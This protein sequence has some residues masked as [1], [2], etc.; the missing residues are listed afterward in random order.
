MFV[1][2]N[3]SICLSYE[4][5]NGYGYDYGWGYGWPFVAT[6]VAATTAA[7]L[8]VHLPAWYFNYLFCLLLV[9]IFF[10]SSLH[11]PSHSLFCSLIST[12]S[13][14][15]SSKLQ[16]EKLSRRTLGHMCAYRILAVISG[17]RLP[18]EMSW[19]RVC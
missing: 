18:C 14:I 16:P 10:F 17:L 6:H 19:P 3:Q 5:G 13:I 4:C 9:S 15:N 8:L 2:K 1:I 12:P 11:S 7:L